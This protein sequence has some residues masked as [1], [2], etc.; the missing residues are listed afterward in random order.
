MEASSS[1]LR[2]PVSREQDRPSK[3]ARLSEDQ[4]G[5]RE[6]SRDRRVDDYRGARKIVGQ[7]D[8]DGERRKGR[9]MPS[10]S[11]RVDFEPGK[12]S[13]EYLD[14]LF[15]GRKT[16][17]FMT[18]VLGRPEDDKSRKVR[19]SGKFWPSDTRIGVPDHLSHYRKTTL[20]QVDA[21]SD[22]Q[23][24]EDRA[25]ARDVKSFGNQEYER[26]LIFL[27][28]PRYWTDAETNKATNVAFNAVSYFDAGEI[29]RDGGLE[30]ATLC[31]KQSWC[32]RGSA[33]S[34]YRTE[35]PWSV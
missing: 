19:V 10:G 29:I 28:E 11:E 4:S 16:R 8:A 35:R 7:Y 31:K 3:R 13:R 6:K 12:M 26:C 2:A 27:Q 15:D 32:R 18:Y 20:V 5:R 21:E 33:R 1:H 34:P 22:W 23:M 24:F 14:K 17:N 9:W 25:P 30:V